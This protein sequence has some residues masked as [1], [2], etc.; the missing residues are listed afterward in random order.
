M[1]WKGRV[2]S[3]LSDQY[4]RHAGV[5]NEPLKEDD[6]LLTTPGIVVTPHVG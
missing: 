4:H 1:V 3:P 6:I 2:K 5:E